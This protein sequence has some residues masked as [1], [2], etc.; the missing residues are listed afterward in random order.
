MNDDNKNK[1]KI[2][3]NMILEALKELDDQDYS[4]RDIIKINQQKRAQL[5]SDIINGRFNLD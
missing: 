1:N 4:I 2:D 3:M 5:I